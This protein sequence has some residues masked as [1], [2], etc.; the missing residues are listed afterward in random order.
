MNDWNMTPPPPIP[1]APL[2]PAVTGP[3]GSPPPGSDPDDRIPISGAVTAVEA[4]L[5][6]PRRVVFHLRESGPGSVIVPLLIV[7]VFCGLVYGVVVGSFSGGNQFWA[8]PVKVAVGLILSALICLPSLYIFS[9]LGGSQARLIEVIGLV[10]GLLGLMT[11]LLIGFAPVAWVFSQSTKS[12]AAM[13]ALHLAFWAIAA[14][15]G[16]RFLRAGFGYLGEPPSGLW[17]WAPVFLLVMLQMTT[18]LRPLVGTSDQFLPTEK[19]FFV[20][21][22]AECLKEP[23]PGAHPRGGNATPQPLNRQ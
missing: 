17:A 23:P 10:A 5:R 18:T 14:Y 3:P 1:P 12:V 20:S 21:H 19:K 15:F 6:H 4:I 9:C 7:A 2:T 22:W 16:L 8:A 13:G 11:V